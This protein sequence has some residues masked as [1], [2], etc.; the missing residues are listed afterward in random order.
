MDAFYLIVDTSIIQSL[1]LIKC[2]ER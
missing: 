1:L 2:E